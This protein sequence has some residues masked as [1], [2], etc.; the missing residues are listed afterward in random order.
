MAYREPLPPDCPPDDA[1]EIAG[2]YIVYRLVR[3]NP[4]VDGDFRS[5]LAEN[6]S[7]TLHNVTKCQA[8]GLSVFS[9]SSD[10]LRR[11]KSGKLKGAMLCEVTLD[12]G[13]GRIRRT[14]SRSGHQTWWPLADFDI[15]AN[16]R[17][18]EL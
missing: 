15:L 4:P 13:S 1:V 6:P 11:T 5:Q 17:V 8:R 7:M 16:C 3:H 14:G 9:G 10:A 18:V 12:R 2:P